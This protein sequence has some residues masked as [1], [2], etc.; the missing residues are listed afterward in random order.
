MSNELLI[1]PNVEVTEN[2]K[3]V[4]QERMDPNVASFIMAAAQAAQ[5]VKLRKLEESK[6]PTGAT[7]LRRTVTDSMTSLDLLPRWISFS[8]TNDGPGAITV[9]VNEI[10]WVDERADFLLDGMIP[11]GESLNV[12]MK[13]PV[14]HT[15]YLKANAGTNALVRIYGK[16]G[17]PST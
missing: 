17:L 14:I 16:E 5:L 12:D 4:S 9:W 7:M 15:L 3:P 1:P 11:S 2:G 10:E 6:I 13:F 8:L